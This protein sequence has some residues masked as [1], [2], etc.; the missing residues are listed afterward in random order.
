MTCNILRNKFSTAIS[1]NTNLLYSRTQSNQ[2]SVVL[3]MFNVASNNFWNT[4]HNCVQNI[5]KFI[6]L[7]IASVNE[8]EYKTMKHHD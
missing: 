4:F 2:V 7:L 5:L 8:K 1:C 3:E 6:I